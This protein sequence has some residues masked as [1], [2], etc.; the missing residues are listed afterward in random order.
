M[1]KNPYL[2]LTIKRKTSLLEKYQQTLTNTCWQIRI[3]FGLLTLFISI[4]Y[5]I[6]GTGFTTGAK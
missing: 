3:P 5:G 2:T 1:P 4:G 6:L